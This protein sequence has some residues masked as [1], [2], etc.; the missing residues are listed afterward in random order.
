MAKVTMT[1]QEAAQAAIDVQDACNLSGVLRMWNQ[2][3]GAVVEAVD[4]TGARNRHAIAVCF[5]SK[6]ADLAGLATDLDGF[7]EAF[8]ACQELVEHG[9]AA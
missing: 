9:E 7:G 2:A 4:S 6:A 8:H 1:L 3:M 5:A